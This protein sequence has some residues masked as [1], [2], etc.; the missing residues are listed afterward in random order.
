MQLTFTSGTTFRAEGN[1]KVWEGTVTYPTAP[2]SVAALSAEFSTEFVRPLNVTSVFQN[3]L[4]WFG[5]SNP[6]QNPIPGVGFQRGVMSFSASNSSALWFNNI[7]SSLQGTPSGWN[8][9]TCILGISSSV[10]PYGTAS[11]SYNTSGC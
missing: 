10:G 9:E 4:L 2:R 7:G 5:N 3:N 6:E 11:A 8:F 1:G